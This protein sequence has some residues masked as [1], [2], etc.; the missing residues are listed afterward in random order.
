MKCMYIPG[1]LVLEL[2]GPCQEINITHTI[3]AI[4]IGSVPKNR[5]ELPSLSFCLVELLVRCCKL[6]LNIERS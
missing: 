3:S 5:S 2:S 1:V 6:C 4:H